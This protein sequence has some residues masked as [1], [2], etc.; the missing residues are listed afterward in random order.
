LHLLL[1]ISSG[2]ICIIWKEKACYWFINLSMLVKLFVP[3]KVL[4]WIWN[5][6]CKSIVAS[7]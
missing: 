4:F 5:L 3:H 2:S 6:K 7:M 1:L